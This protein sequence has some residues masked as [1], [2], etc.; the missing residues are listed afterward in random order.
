LQI[1]LY[2]SDNF[3]PI[4]N[5]RYFK[6]TVNELFNKTATSVSRLQ[7]PRSLGHEIS[8]PARTLGSWARIPLMAWMLFGV[9]SVFVLSC[10]GSSLASGWSPVQGVL[11]TDYR[12][13]KLKWNEVFHGCPM[14]QV[15]ATRI[16]R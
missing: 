8:S 15:G 11:P 7:W 9:Y 2:P 4:V 16:D 6:I 10:V 12:I 5:A 3:K 1:K 14:L 13:K